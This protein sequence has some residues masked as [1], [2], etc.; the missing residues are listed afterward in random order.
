ML[1]CSVVPITLG[2]VTT[3]GFITPP[4]DPSITS[5]SISSVSSIVNLNFV[6]SSSYVQCDFGSGPT[7]CSTS[8]P[9]EVA[10]NVQTAFSV[11]LSIPNDAYQVQ[12]LSYTF[13]LSQVPACTV[14]NLAV[15]ASTVQ[16]DDGSNNY[17]AAIKP[18]NS[19]NAT[20]AFSVDNSTACAGL[21]VGALL[22]NLTAAACTL[23]S[24]S[25]RS[26]YSCP[27]AVGVTSIA[28]VYSPLPSVVLPVASASISAG[29][30]LILSRVFLGLI[31]CEVFLVLD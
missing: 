11:T 8:F 17:L 2:G 19:S 6:Q 20:I 23:T 5:Y 14:S 28:V 16:N 3:D 15:I 13:T 24:S 26:Y 27:I 7:S 25:D 10:A 9:I 29:A 30:F 31:S 1:S 12:D 18:S 22:P 21:M 4:F